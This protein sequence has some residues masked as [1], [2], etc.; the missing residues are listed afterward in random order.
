MLPLLYCSF[1]LRSDSLPAMC[2]L[3]GE[4][5]TI[6]TSRSLSNRESLQARRC[7]GSLKC[8]RPRSLVRAGGAGG[9]ARPVATRAAPLYGEDEGA[10][11]A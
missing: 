1:A 8:E 10:P 6:S 7:D 4:F 5:A 3:N 2:I 9:A 11:C